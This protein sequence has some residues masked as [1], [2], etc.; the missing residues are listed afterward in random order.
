LPEKLTETVLNAIAEMAYFD[1]VDKVSA[2]SLAGSIQ[3]V[4]GSPRDLRVDLFEKPPGETFLQPM[5]RYIEAHGGAVH[6]N[7]ELTGIRVTDERVS[8][9][10]AA[11]PG[12]GTHRETRCS[13]C[14]ALLVSDGAELP[15]C[16]VCG[17]NGDMI[18]ILAHEDLQERQFTADYFISCM[19]VPS[20][21]RFYGDNLATLGGHDYFRN[22][23]RLHAAHVYVVVMWFADGSFWDQRVTDGTGRPAFDFFATGFDHLGISLNWGTHVTLDGKSTAL[24]KEY[25]DRN[26]AVIE[27]QIANA[28]PLAGLG[29]EEIVERVYGELKILMP[30]IPAIGASYVNRWRNYTAYRVG[31]MENRPGMQSPLDNLLFAGDMPFVDHPAVFMEKTNVTAKL[32]TNLLLEKI[33]Q[34]QGRIKI[35]P[36]GTPNALVSFFSRFNSVFP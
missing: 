23:N 9:V 11:Q 35:L 2:L 13:V 10:V 7:T 27:T 15:R 22:I 4:C 25:Q 17:A 36:S 30:D 26:V 3:L 24:V 12:D 34:E 28:E 32:A 16:P 18:K 5:V 14:G 6:F 33:G 1:D 19:D 31:D 29:D 8:S 21:R 20:S